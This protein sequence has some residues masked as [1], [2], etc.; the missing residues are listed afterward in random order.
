[1]FIP[2]VIFLIQNITPN[3]VHYNIWSEKKAIR[4]IDFIKLI[5]FLNFVIIIKQM[6][7]TDTIKLMPTLQQYDQ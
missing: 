6:R 2:F 5:Y 7:C 4:D 1:M 3:L